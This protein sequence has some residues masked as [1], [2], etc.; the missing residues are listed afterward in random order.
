MMKTS[1]ASKSHIRTSNT[2]IAYYSRWNEIFQKFEIRGKE[3]D[4]LRH[5]IE[6]EALGIKKSSKNFNK[7]DFDICFSVARKLLKNGDVCISGND[8]ALD[9][10]Q[11]E[12]RRYVFAIE[13]ICESDDYISEIANDKFGVANWRM[14]SSYQ[15]WQ[16]LIT[17]KNRMSAITKKRQDTNEPF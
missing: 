6:F 2:R 17:V 10:E 9:A 11:G 5:E 15:L 1:R 14:L 4:K 7:R 12:C 3:R 13:K 8:A 16:L